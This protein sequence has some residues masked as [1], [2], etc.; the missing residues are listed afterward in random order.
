MRQY[1]ILVDRDIVRH[2][3]ARVSHEARRASRSKRRRNSLDHNVRARHVERL[4]L[5]LRHTLTEGLGDQQDIREQGKMFFGRNLGQII[6]SV[7]PDFL[8]VIPNREDNGIHQ[9]ED[10]ALALRLVHVSRGSRCKQIRIQQRW[11]TGLAMKE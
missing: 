6:E 1:V 9:C 4:E 11:A 7:V 8:H 2:N 3:V 5:D 10:T